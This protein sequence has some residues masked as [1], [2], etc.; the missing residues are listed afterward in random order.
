MTFLALKAADVSSGA[1]AAGFSIYFSPLPDVHAFPVV[2]LDLH[3]GGD[4]YQACEEQYRRRAF[5]ASAPGE[6]FATIRAYQSIRVTT[7]ERVGLDV[8]HTAIVVNVASRAKH[9]LIVATGKIDPGFNPAPLLLVIHNQSSRP[10]KLRVGD[11]IAAIAFAKASAEAAATTSPGHA[12][13]P[14]GADF[15]PPLSAKLL[16]RLRNV[17]W[18]TLAWDAAKL[19]IA[20]ALTLLTIYVAYM[21]G[22]RRDP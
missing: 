19:F 21:L 15:E 20:A 7:K 12:L 1:V 13:A 5:K 17:E 10:I 22:W 18:S 6:G 11:K 8:N 9:G 3:V 2:W 4:S 16:E 14:L